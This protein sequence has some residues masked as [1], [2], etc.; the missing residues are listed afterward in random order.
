MLT[1]FKQNNSNFGN[2][3]DFKIEFGHTAFV[4]T[5]TTRF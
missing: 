2:E 4:H 3:F 5:A 1:L